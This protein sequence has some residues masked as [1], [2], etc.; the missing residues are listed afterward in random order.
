MCRC[1]MGQQ[2]AD[3]QR[4][5]SL[6]L[7]AL[8]CVCYNPHR[9]VKA[10]G[11]EAGEKRWGEL[12]SMR[13]C[14]LLLI[15]HNTRVSVSQS[16]SQTSSFSARSTVGQQSNPATVVLSVCACGLIPRQSASCCLLMNVGISASSR[17][18]FGKML[19]LAVSLTTSA[20]GE[21]K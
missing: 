16:V 21:E 10:F 3:S 2:Q 5:L 12:H 17:G 1:I 6:S 19:L 8:C 9:P 20:A 18:H 7:Y 11:S 14:R 15:F 13:L 4:L